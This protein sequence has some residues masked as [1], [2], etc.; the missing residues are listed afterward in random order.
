M[1]R[2]EEYKALLAELD[3]MPPELEYTVQ[4]AIARKKQTRR[5]WRAFGIPAGSLAACFLGFMLLVNLFPTVAYA[6][7]GVPGLRELAKA[8]AWSPSLSAAVDDAYVQPMGQSQTVNGITATVEY[9]IVD[10]K[11]VNIYYT[12]DSDDWT[13]ME[14][15]IPNATDPSGEHLPCSIGNGSFNVP[16]GE[17]REINLDFGDTDVPDSLQLSL[18]AY[19]DNIPREPGAPQETSYED[20][21]FETPDWDPD[22]VAEFTFDLT[23]DPYFT[24]QGE[25]IPVNQSFTLD[26]QTLTVTEAEVYPSHV[27]V[28]VTGAADNTAWLKDLDFYLE[29]ERGQRFEPISNGITATGDANSPAMLSYRLESP[30]FSRSQHLTLHF[31]GAKWLDKDLE[32]VRVDLEHKTADFLPEGVEFLKA[33]HRKGG[34]LVSFKAP[35]AP[36][37]GFYQLFSSQFWDADGNQHDIMTHGSSSYGY[38][39]PETGEYIHEDGFFEEE[40]PLKDFHGTEVWLEPIST[41]V[42][43]EPT[44]VRI[45]IK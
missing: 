39:N 10:Q 3:Q 31:T 12:L 28:N 19:D 22:Y 25:I 1:N 15:D 11:Q 33:D 16:N 37:G 30:Y 7:G 17:L 45:P 32:R 8:V 42:T 2:N 21:M 35:E 27:R 44:P 40:F 24:A 13:E 5:K 43:V 9:V 18:S 4:R 23:F 26:G 41:R 14:I 38:T 6:C 36:G 29:N 34:W 20:D